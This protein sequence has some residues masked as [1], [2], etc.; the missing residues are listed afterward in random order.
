MDMPVLA[1]WA[2]AEITPDVPCRMGGYSARAGL[3][4]AVHDALYAHALALGTPERPFVIVICDLIGIDEAAVFSLHQLVMAQHPHATLWLGATHTHSGPDVARSLSFSPALLDPAPGQRMIEGAVKAAGEAI[5]HMHEVTVRWARGPINGI[6][7]NRDHPE[8]RADIALDLLCLY[9]T[10]EQ[11]QP[12]ALFGSFPCHP[13]VMGADNLA[14]SADLP[15]VFRRQ[16]KMLLGDTSWIALATGAAGDIS[17]RHTRQGQGFDELERLG[18]QMAQQAYPLLSMVRP[19]KLSQP[20]IRD[21][22]VSL[23]RKK[24]LTSETLATYMQLVQTQMEMERQAGHGAQA[25]TLE[26]VLQGIQAMQEA[27]EKSRIEGE[28]ARDVVIAVARLGELALVAV[29]GELYNCLG[30]EMKQASERFIMILGYTNGYV[31]YLPAREAYEGLD[32]EVLMSPFAP[33]AGERL[34]EEVRSLLE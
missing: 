15:G 27:Q 22:V 8:Q 6:A 5:A 29:P 19:I 12:S 33:G 9:D 3:A 2:M 25:R 14:I 21:K 30:A 7:T 1:G 18:G 16:M 23:E 26:T 34:V 31:G 13:T 11:V 28:E 24:P 10:P 17:T 32:Y 4:N 20:D